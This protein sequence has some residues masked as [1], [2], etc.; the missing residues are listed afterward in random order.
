M[1]EPHACVEPGYGKLQVGI[2]VAAIQDTIDR[3]RQQLPP[4]VSE[5]G[6][7]GNGSTL[8]G[9]IDLRVLY[10]GSGARPEKE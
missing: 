2:Y 3:K 5:P 1:I 7:A 9:N 10:T 6:P 4:L 8:I